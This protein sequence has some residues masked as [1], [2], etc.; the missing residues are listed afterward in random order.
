MSRKRYTPEQIIGRQLNTL[1]NLAI[2]Q[3]SSLCPQAWP[4]DEKQRALS[5]SAPPRF[6]LV[7]CNVSLKM[8][9]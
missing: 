8:S 2:S 3:P 5:Y 4:L 1:I 9:I 7:L 6:I